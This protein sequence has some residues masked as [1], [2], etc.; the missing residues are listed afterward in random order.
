MNKKLI[1]QVVDGLIGIK[2]HIDSDGYEVPQ[3]V[4][5][6]HDAAVQSLK[7]AQSL[8]AEKKYPSNKFQTG[9][10]IPEKFP[11][12]EIENMV[13]VYAGKTN[14]DGLEW[15]ITHGYGND[16]IVY[17]S[18]SDRWF[19]RSP[20]KGSEIELKGGYDEALEYAGSMFHE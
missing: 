12:E 2:E 10:K 18:N 16:I 1:E 14:R 20:R 3:E 6:V 5:D 7:D 8:P 9:S 13:S 19:V 15:Y 11:E 17:L 4:I